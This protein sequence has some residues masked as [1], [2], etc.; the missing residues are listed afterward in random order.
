MGG[1]VIEIPTNPTIIDGITYWKSTTIQGRKLAII[2]NDK[3]PLIE[4]KFHN[5]SGGYDEDYKENYIS[6]E[7]N[8]QLLDY[9]NNKL[10]ELT[11][12][13]RI[14]NHAEVSTFLVTHNYDLLEQ[15]FQNYLISSKF[16][17]NTIFLRSDNRLIPANISAYTDHIFPDNEFKAGYMIESE[18]NLIVIS[19]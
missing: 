17:K 8:K 10:K 18:F 16:Q 9:I 19:N 3:L 12:G 4:E 11:P 6:E 2:P 13:F 5:I 14:P 1:G 7:D 15:D